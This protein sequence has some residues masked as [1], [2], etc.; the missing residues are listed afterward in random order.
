MKGRIC[1]CVKRTL[2]HRECVVSPKASGDKK[3]TVF[4]SKGHWITKMVMFRR[5]SVMP[6]GQPLLCQEDTVSPRGWRFA[7]GHSDAKRA[8]VFV[9]R[10]HCFTKKVTFCQRPHWC[11]ESSRFC[12]KRTLYHQEGDV[13]PEATL[14]PRGKP[15]LCQKDTITKRVTFRQRSHWCQEGNQCSVK[16]TL[17]P[18]GDVLPE[19]T[20]IQSKRVIVVVSRGHYHKEGGIL[21]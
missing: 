6:R 15:L 2:Y 12:V 7:R 10:G 5:R 17:S 1:C 8:T 13:L 14:T 11:Q 4:V 18:R 20:L 19:I 9:S 16:R 3:A 21:P